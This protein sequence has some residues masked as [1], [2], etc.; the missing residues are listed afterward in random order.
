[1]R[2]ISDNVSKHWMYMCTVSY[3]LLSE[4]FISYKK[5]MIYVFFCQQN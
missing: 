5:W 3:Y 4:R 2:H 1:M